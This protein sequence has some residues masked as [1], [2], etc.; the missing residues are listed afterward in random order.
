MAIWA[1]LA[2]VHGHLPRLERA[3]ALCRAHGAERWAFL[4]DLLGRGDSDGCVAL[5]RT[6]ADLSVVGNRDLDWQHRVGAVS[7]DY[8]LSLPT[9]RRGE[10]F[11]VVHGDA[12]LDRELCSA[13][14]RRGFAQSYRRLE[15]E[16]LAIG[17]LGHTH[18]AR[19]WRLPGPGEPPEQLYDAAVDP[20]PATVSVGADTLTTRFVVNVGTVGLPFA[21][22]G[23][24]SCAVLDMESGTV[25]IV[26]LD[27]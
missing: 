17:I 14:E 1:L 16:N 15:R 23:P 9:A 10:N 4:G 26:P 18:R 25:E 19:V 5:V 24:P 20:R 3:V 21:G 6:L 8:V 27:G 11:L 22:K 2:D 12:R 7:R 13:D